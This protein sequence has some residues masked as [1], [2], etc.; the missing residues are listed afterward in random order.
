MTARVRA[1]VRWRAVAVLLVCLLFLLA[2]SRA[3]PIAVVETT[4]GKVERDFA[5]TAGT[6]EGA[7]HGATFELGDGV[8]TAEASTAR[9]VLFDKSLLV[10]EP[11]TLIRF[12]DRPREKGP[13]L[14]V[15]TG[16]ATLEAGDAALD[17][18][19]S[20]GAA[21]LDAHGK[22]RLQRAGDGLRLEVL[23][24]S[25]RML[26]DNEILELKVGDRAELFSDQSPKKLPAE[27]PAT[28]AQPPAVASSGSFAPAVAPDGG[29]RPGLGVALLPDGGGAGNDAARPRGPE[30]VDF[31]TGA[32]DS[33]VVHD[34]KPP[35]AIAFTQNRCPTGAVL[36]LQARGHARETAG[37][38]RV[39]ALFPA[40]STHYT[41]TCAE[42]GAPVASG[43]VSVQADAGS[44]QLARTAPSTQLD[45]DGRSYTVLYQS[46]LPRI[47]VRWPNAPEASSYAL[48]VRS[49]SGARS[50]TS[51]SPGYAFPAGALGEG[52]HTL[53]FEA[54]GR[55]SRPTQVLVRFDNAAPTASIVSPAEGS[56]A[57]GSSVLVAG[58]ALPGWTVSVAGK[59]LVQDP[60]N[61]FSEEVSAPSGQRALLIRFSH[62][63]RGLHYY[64][65]R[66]VSK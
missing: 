43:V 30:S 1:L 31:L 47:S 33:F 2:C 18:D 24:G 20:Y 7:A 41:I 48:S 32:G 51:G 14:D 19:L 57:A 45:A 36:T 11:V 49:S 38:A 8:K 27:A 28:A 5:K 40:G 16:S 46:L 37:D 54:A 25:A 58:S 12:L 21:R 17:V 22:L 52:D 65:K 59:E 61:R 10:L 26:G 53:T 56:F 44:R 23:I 9:L 63:S 42:G 50:F 29:A 15:M 39:S 35:T 34:P 4:A 60:Q 6:W 66:S 64:L 3:S 55:R 13:K 62:P